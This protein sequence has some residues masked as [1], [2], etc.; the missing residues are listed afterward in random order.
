MARDPTPDPRPRPC[1]APVLGLL[2]ALSGCGGGGGTDAASLALDYLRPPPPA[3][4]GDAG[5]Q[6]HFAP[7]QFTVTTD[8]GVVVRLTDRGTHRVA[9]L[10]GVAAGEHWLYLVDTTYCAE[11]PA[12][13]TALTGV[14]LNGTPLARPLEPGSGG[15]ACTA[16]RFTLT[17]DG[18][19]VP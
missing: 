5:C 19:V 16:L 15:P 9:S 7:A 12:C 13:P 6:H 11:R 18:A 4:P 14:T 2:L 10:P 8:Q 17:A 1:V 3:D